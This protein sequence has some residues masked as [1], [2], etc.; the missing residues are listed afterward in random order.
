MLVC[1]CTFALESVSLVHYLTWLNQDRWGNFC[2]DFSFYLWTPPVL[3][4]MEQLLFCQFVLKKFL[5]WFDL[6]G[7]IFSIYSKDCLVILLVWQH[8]II[9]ISIKFHPWCFHLYIR[10]VMPTFFET[11]F[12]QTPYSL[13]Q[14]KQEQK[15]PNLLILNWVGRHFNLV[16]EEKYNYTN[17]LAIKY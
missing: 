9:F 16:W 8:M 6:T 13:S 2:I 17:Y 7:P 11:D 10:K 12:N 1:S 15:F 5:W 4:E 14:E 3:G